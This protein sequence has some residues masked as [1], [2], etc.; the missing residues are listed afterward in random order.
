[1]ET[2]KFLLNEQPKVTIEQIEETV[3]FNMNILYDGHADNQQIK[4]M[5]S[6]VAANLNVHVNER[7]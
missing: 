6:M 7:V 4:D 5:I 2:F 3:R 1:M